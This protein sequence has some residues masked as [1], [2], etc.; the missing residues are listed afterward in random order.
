MFSLKMVTS[1]TEFVV[2]MREPIVRI[3][4]TTGVRPSG[5][6]I[7]NTRGQRKCIVPTISPPRHHYL[8]SELCYVRSILNNLEW[9]ISSYS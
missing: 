8:A 9:L 6:G 7:K 2:L 5:N 4:I 3:I 1:S